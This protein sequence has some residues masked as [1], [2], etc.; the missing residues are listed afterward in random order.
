MLQVFKKLRPRL[1]KSWLPVLLSIVLAIVANSLIV[2]TSFSR[3]RSLEQPVPPTKD[4]R[5]LYGALAEDIVQIFKWMEAPDITPI[6]L[7]MNVAGFEIQ[8]DQ[9]YL[10][11]D[12]L[13]RGLPSSH[14][15]YK[16]DIIANQYNHGVSIFMSG[17]PTPSGKTEMSNVLIEPLEFKGKE[18]TW[19]DKFSAISFTDYLLKGAKKTDR[20]IMNMGAGA[21]MNIYVDQ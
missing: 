17:S 8:P 4:I 1:L 7:A 21:G 6:K 2:N 3:I 13:Y 12:S 20:E 11:P 19:Y 9:V 16:N 18:K 10:S 5:I 14:G 15:K